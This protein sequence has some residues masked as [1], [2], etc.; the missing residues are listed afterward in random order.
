MA[1]WRENFRKS[2]RDIKKRYFDLCCDD[3]T[4]NLHKTVYWFAASGLTLI[5][6]A[7]FWFQWRIAVKAFTVLWHANHFH[8]GISISHIPPLGDA[9]L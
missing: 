8:T 3:D 1:R 5:S 4:N 2:P 9:K 7:T 6:D